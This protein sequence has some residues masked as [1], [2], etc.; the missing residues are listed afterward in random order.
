MP[1]SGIVDEAAIDTGPAELNPMSRLGNAMAQWRID[2]PGL[3]EELQQ[4]FSFLFDEVMMLTYQWQTFNSLFNH[5]KK[6]VDLINATAPAFFWLIQDNLL[7]QMILLLA[8]LLDRKE[9]CKKRNATFDHF[10][11]TL[12]KHNHQLADELRKDRETLKT[13]FEPFKT[14]RDRAIGHNDYRTAHKVELLP[15]FQWNQLSQCIELAQ[16]WVEKPQ[17]FY[18]PECSF[19]W[20]IPDVGGTEAIISVLK[21]YRAM[22]EWERSDWRNRNKVPRSS[23]DDA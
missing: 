17:E 22:M 10:A 20:S 4:E 6:R 5:S 12:E 7:D 19:I 13:E 9:T 1:F 21:S 8:R 14:W 23:F 16:Q 11:A 18:S 15:K 2:N 3:P